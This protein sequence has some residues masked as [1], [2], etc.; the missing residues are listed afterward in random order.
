MPRSL[1][2]YNRKREFGTP[3][4]AGRVDYNIDGS[5]SWANYASHPRGRQLTASEGHPWFVKP[6]P[7]GDVGGPFTTIK[8]EVTQAHETHHSYSTGGKHPWT[9]K[10]DGIIYPWSNPSYRLG[11]PFESDSSSPSGVIQQAW[12][13][14]QSSSDSDLL[15]Q[16][17]IAV[18]RCKPTNSIAEVSVS[19]GELFRDGLPSI[20]LLE[21]WKERSFRAK[22]AG[23]EYL[24]YQFGWLPL[25]SDIQNFAKAVNQSG[26][27]LKQLERDS[28]RVVR[29]RYEFPIETSTTIYEDGVRD[30][31]Y[32]SFPYYWYVNNDEWC[33]RTSTKQI[34][35]R[36]WFS[37]AFTYYI[38]K[39]GS[40]TDRIARGYLE[41][42]KLFGTGITPETLWN[43]TPWSW[44]TDWVFNTGSVISNLTDMA[45]YG[46]V[47]PYGYIME[48][49]SVKYTFRTKGA[50]LKGGPG[51]KP[52]DLEFTIKKRRQASPFG[53]G[54]SWN[55]FDN[56]QM[57]I[58]AALGFS[59]ARTA[60]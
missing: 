12:S 49:T 14:D 57:A 10:F 46:L 15:A 21:S 37:G 31:P 44:A 38:P 47:M 50:V 23:S 51:V 24:N 33:Y 56:T 16:G 19:L 32:P 4:P 25:V 7:K 11:R 35:K 36:R 6:R 40:F 53:F 45:Q 3:L 48:E 20:P 41:A 28:G 1:S 2:D 8:M 26:K 54:L 27:I 43:L 22:N 55:G 42:E 18:D 5:T 60:R 39:G 52:L 30:L 59:R 9:I 34:T 17:T 58:L 13:F 29:R